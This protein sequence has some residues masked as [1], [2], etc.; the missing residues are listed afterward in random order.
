MA[1]LAARRLSEMVSLG[2]E[3]AAIELAVATRALHLRG[4]ERIGAGSARAR[5]MVLDRVPI[6]EPDDPVPGELEP[7]R[8]LVRSGDLSMVLD[9]HREEPDSGMT[10]G[11]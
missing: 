5:R 2:E 3:L 9:R 8:E 11:R 6:P 7:L 10:S 4:P 1:P